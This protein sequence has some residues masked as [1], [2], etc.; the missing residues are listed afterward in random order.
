MGGDFAFEQRTAADGTEVVV[1]AAANVIAAV[2][3]GTN[4]LLT[5]SNGTGLLVLSVDGIFG[6][7]AADIS[8]DP[9]AGVALAGQ[10]SILINTT[11]AAQTPA[12]IIQPTAPQ[13]TSLGISLNI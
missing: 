10:L 6:K 13:A 9:A 7:A 1:V 5:A 11:T 3:D 2:S 4:D 12:N 8:V